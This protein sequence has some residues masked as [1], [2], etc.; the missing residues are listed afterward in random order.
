MDI[1][2]IA[3]AA[4]ILDVIFGDPEFLYH[5]VRAIGFIISKIQMFLLP[6]AKTKTAEFIYGVILFVITTSVS[7]LFPF[8]ILHFSFRINYI[9]YIILQIIF[10]Y[11]MLACKCLSFTSMRVYKALK[12]ND[13]V[14]AREYLSHI[15][16]R[17]TERLTEKEIIKSACE[18]VSENT[19][20]GVVSPLFYI[21][22]GGAPLVFLYKAIS[23]LDSMVGYTSEK[24]FY[25][26]KV[27]ARADDIASFI[28]SRIAAMFMIISSFILRLN[29]KNAFYIFLR[30]RK[31]H[32]SPNSGNTESVCAGALSIELAGDGYYYGK[33]IRKQAIGDSIKEPEAD[34]IKK[35]NYLMYA[36]S[37]MTLIF[38]VIVRTILFTAVIK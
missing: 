10:C 34:D 21:F 30:D 15:V 1:V 25:F 31:K 22:I 2:Y 9:L 38:G 35:A 27:S 7:F 24:Y 18:S 20:D 14:K 32:R 8:V 19:T 3:A 16:G 6:K 36:T 13:I 26:G 29:Y 4:F 28:P 37:I 33:L 17:E 11:Q 5:P 23:T 12:E